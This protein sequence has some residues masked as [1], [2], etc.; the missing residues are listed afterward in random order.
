MKNKV[1]KYENF[2]DEGKS[3]VTINF[4]SHKYGKSIEELIEIFKE[5][6][7]LY[8][9]GKTLYL[10]RKHKYKKYAKYFKENSKNV[11]KFTLKGEMFID[12]LLREGNY[13]K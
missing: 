7:F 12:N 10:Y 5:K 8:R 11:L 9:K 1:L 13:E 2:F 4:L 3:Y 6:K